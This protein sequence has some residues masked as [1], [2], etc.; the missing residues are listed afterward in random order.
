MIWMCALHLRDCQY[1]LGFLSKC[2]FESL[3]IVSGIIGDYT[4]IQLCNYVSVYL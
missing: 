1:A 4:E 3:T 2:A